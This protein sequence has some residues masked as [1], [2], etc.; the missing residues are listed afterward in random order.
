M[1]KSKR[2]EFLFLFESQNDDY[3]KNPKQK[4]SNSGPSVSGEIQNGTEIT[5]LLFL[6]IVW[7]VFNHTH[8]A[9]RIWNNIS[10]SFID[11]NWK[12]P[13]WFILAARRKGGCWKRLL[14]LWGLSCERKKKSPRKG[15]VE[16]SSQ[17][18]LPQEACL[19][20]KKTQPVVSPQQ[21]SKMWWPEG[22]L[23]G[24]QSWW[25]RQEHPW[26]TV[27]ATEEYWL[28]LRTGCRVAT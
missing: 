12:E 24:G 6:C 20:E 21:G 17:E 16:G 26:L 19:K 18:W 4:F 3:Q 25:L 23:G 11:K 28:R 22:Q 10:N 9:F 13:L 14:P 1:N 7:N 15:K 5:L 2:R 27:K 8:I